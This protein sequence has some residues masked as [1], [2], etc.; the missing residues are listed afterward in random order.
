MRRLL[1]CALAAGALL[2]AGCA[3]QTRS[4][5]RAPPADLPAA[6]SNDATP[7]FEQDAF[8]CGPASLAMAL[9]AAGLPSTPE[10]LAGSVFLPGRQGSL[11]IEML[12]AARSRGAVAFRI[13]GRLDALLRELAAGR[14]VIVLQNLGLAI[15]P[16]WHYA[17]AIGYDL[18]AEEIL[19][20]SG[21]HQ[22]LRMP[23]ST[24]EHTWDRS[25]R[26]AFVA[27]AP[28]RLPATADEREVV[29]ALVAFERTAPPSAA[30]Q[31]Y[32]AAA[33]RWPDNLAIAI[34]LGNSAYASGDRLAAAAAFRAAAG[35]HGDGAALNNLAV[36]LDELG[37]TDEALQ[38]A[39]SAA[40]RPGPWRDAARATLE[41]IEARRRGPAAR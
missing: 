15:E 29:A 30:R 41:R 17:V 4:L 3:T 36:V 8:H 19:L 38:A 40:E 14:P 1:A 27:L 23:M 12:A 35:R 39:R 7:Y 13:P 18:A 11:Q 22:R 16:V 5:L 28:G 10:A 25:G 32:G 37:E 20:R 21:P 9:S 2:L 24:F 31:A 33:E 6:A 26:W 34:G